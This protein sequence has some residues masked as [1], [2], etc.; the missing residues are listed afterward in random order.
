MKAIHL[1]LATLVVSSLACVTSPI[2]P[3]PEP[4]PETLEWATERTAGAGAF[5]GL[6]TRENDSGS[7]DE[8]FFRPGVRVTQVVENSPAAEAG[9]RIGDV[10]LA[11]DGHDLNDPDALD[12]L[13]REAS[14]GARASVR[15]QRGDAVFEVPVRLHPA[16]G[17]PAGEAR[18]A[19]RLDP[20]R[21]R[22][23][24]ATGHGGAVLVS[25]DEDA[26]FPRAGVPVGSVIRTV[27]GREILSARSLIRLLQ[28]RE[29]GEDVDVEVTDPDGVERVMTVALQEQPTRLTRFSFPILVHFDADPEGESTSFTLID[30][31]IISLFH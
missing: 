6:K 30:L 24:W 26:P 3:I 23:S 19:Y 9:F 21:S 1:A 17:E 5:L 8:L 13:L 7:L 15:V 28:A 22:A 16:G 18:L 2:E 14:A 29:P 25:S 11:F 10:V 31:W 20:S 12:T 4:L 27:D